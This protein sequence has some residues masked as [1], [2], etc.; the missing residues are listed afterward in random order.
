MFITGVSIGIGLLFV[1]LLYLDA[2]QFKAKRFVAGI[3]ALLCWLLTGTFMLDQGAIQ[4]RLYIASIPTAFFLLLPLIYGY[5]QVLIAY[6]ADVK[7]IKWAG[8][9]LPVLPAVLLSASIGLMPTNDFN[10][11]FFEESVSAS[12]WVSINS[13][14]FALLLLAWT[15]LSLV[16]LGKIV[17]STKVYHQQL[18]KEFS[19]HEGKRLDWLVGLTGLLV[20]TWLYA[21]IV[22]GLSAE[23]S[24]L[25]ISETLVSLLVLTLIWVFAVQALNRKPAFAMTKVETPTEAEDRVEQKYSNSAIDEERLERIAKKI[26]QRVKLEQAYL[27]PEL[28]ASTLASDLGISGHYLSQVFSQTMQ[29]TFYNYINDA[30]I[31]AA[32]AA[33]KTSEDTVLDIALAVGFNTRSSFYNAFKKRTGMTPSAFKSNASAS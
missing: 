1:S 17:R 26:E 2:N 16:Y 15:A 20:F 27:N 4:A 25:F 19:N 29:T 24:S 28:D 32:K 5:Q 7:A 31:D 10:A 6:G 14:G 30:R 12:L 3:V 13:L 18:Q 22:L 11:M 33:L 8:H 23:V 21:L 9:W